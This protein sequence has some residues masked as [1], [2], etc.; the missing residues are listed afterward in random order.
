MPEGQHQQT[1]APAAHEEGRGADTKGD[2]DRVLPTP[3][4]MKGMAGHANAPYRQFIN[5]CERICESGRAH[6]IYQIL[7]TLNIMCPV[8]NPNII[9]E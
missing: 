2:N 9:F 5:C 6:F 3:R 1:N 8:F 4:I 7:S